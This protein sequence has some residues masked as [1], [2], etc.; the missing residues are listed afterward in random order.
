MSYD[1]VVEFHLSLSQ[2]LNESEDASDF[3]NDATFAPS[4]PRSLNE[5]EDVKELDIKQNQTV[6]LF[7]YLWFQYR[8]V[9]IVKQPDEL[10]DVLNKFGFPSLHVGESLKSAKE[11]LAKVEEQ[12]AL[13]ERRREELEEKSRAGGV[14]GL[15][16]TY[17]LNTLNTGPL[18]ASLRASVIT[19]EAAVRLVLKDKNIPRKSIS[20]TLWWIERQIDSNKTHLV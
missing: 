14:L 12:L 5:K 1:T 3:K 13:Y 11:S 15:V 18:A 4:L 9:L 6:L 8:D 10:V 20:G 7:E 2:W 17:Q 16:H 19:A